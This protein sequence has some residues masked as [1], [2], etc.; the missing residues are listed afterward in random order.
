MSELEKKE[1]RQGLLDGLWSLLR[2]GFPLLSIYNI[3]GPK[4]LLHIKQLST[5]DSKAHA[6]A[7]K[8]AIFQFINSCVDELGIGKDNMFIISE[9][10]GNDTLKFS[11]VRPA[12]FPHCPKAYSR[13]LELNQPQVLFIINKVLDIAQQRKLIPRL[14]HKPRVRDTE[15]TSPT[16]KSSRIIHELV[17]TEQKYALD[18]ENL[19]D[20]KKALEESGVVTGDVL[21]AILPNMRLILEFQSRFLVRME[22][23]YSMPQEK[24]RWGSLFVGHKDAFVAAYQ[25]FFAKQRERGRLALELFGKIHSVQHPVAHDYNTL[26]GFLIKPMQRLSKY[27]MFL[28]VSVIQYMP[29]SRQLLITQ[30][31][32]EK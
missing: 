28:R 6:Q 8:F 7:A 14:T 20:L 12:H 1:Q 22:E 9:L 32:D 31:P 19:L 5:T 29:L 13:T 3:T 26:D 4:K 24:Q 18:L 21:N 17:D 2:T 30:G 11:K 23:M 27:P 25:P 10:M 15:I 16:P